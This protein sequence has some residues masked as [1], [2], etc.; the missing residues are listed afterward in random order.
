MTD[1]TLSRVV[2]FMFYFTQASPSASCL[3]PLAYSHLCGLKFTIKWT[4][5]TDPVVNAHICTKGLL[6]HSFMIGWQMSIKG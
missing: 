3:R 2:M 6:R 5:A 1:R 4:H